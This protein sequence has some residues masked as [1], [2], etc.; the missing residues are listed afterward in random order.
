MGAALGLGLTL[1]GGVSMSRSIK[2]GSKTAAITHI[3]G[4]IA[5]RL[6]IFVLGF[7]LLA[8]TGWAHP[9]AYALAFVIGVLAAMVRQLVVFVRA[10]EPVVAS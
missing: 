6:A 3:Y 2:R 1:L 5:L 7:L 10:R 9:V 8:S 4:G